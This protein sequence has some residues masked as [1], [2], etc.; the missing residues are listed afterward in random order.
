MARLLGVGADIV[1]PQSTWRGRTRNELRDYLAKQV[2]E[3][4]GLCVAQL[5]KDKESVDGVNLFREIDKA[6]GEFIKADYG[7]DS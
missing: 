1:I 3:A 6:I 7:N 5:R 4:I 2:R